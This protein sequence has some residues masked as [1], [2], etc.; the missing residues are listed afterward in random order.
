MLMNKVYCIILCTIFI[1]F[2]F[3]TSKVYAEDNDTEIQL[4]TSDTIK[5][6]KGFNRP[7][8]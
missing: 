2:T 4:H 3:G 7:V 1:F 8:R 6:N 5:N